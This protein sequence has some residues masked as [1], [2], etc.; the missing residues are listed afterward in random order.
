M[1]GR[2]GQQDLLGAWDPPPLR[3]PLSQL[4]VFLDN[5]AGM[6]PSTVWLMG[7]TS[8]LFPRPPSLGP[9]TLSSHNPSDHLPLRSSVPR[10]SLN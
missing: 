4:G 8:T 10:L 2:S 6:S 1:G 7:P 9:S 3:E 5:E